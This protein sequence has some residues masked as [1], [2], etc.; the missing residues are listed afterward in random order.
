MPTEAVEIAR[1]ANIDRTQFQKQFAKP[2]VP[3]VIEGLSH[4]WPAYTKWTLDYFKSICGDKVVPLYDSSKADASK[5]VNQADHQMKFGDY[6]DL[7]ARE[8]TDL[9]IFTFNVIDEMPQIEADFRK[10][11]LCRLFVDRFPMMFF[12]GAGSKVFMHYDIDVPHIFLTQFHGSKRVLL[13]PPN[14]T[15]RLY[16]LPL[17][18]HAIEDIDWWNP[19]Y[20]KFPA[21]RGITGYTTILKHGET[22]YMPPGWW[23]YMEYLEGGFAIA[24]RAVASPWRAAEGAINVGLIR[25]IDN[26]LRKRAGTKW[27]E[28]KERKAYERSNAWARKH[29][30]TSLTPAG[31]LQ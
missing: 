19:D 21:L 18:W 8:P 13:F 10:P 5:K 27:W 11:D 26:F 16:K 12:G 22:L 9:R 7:I 28:Y 15:P 3:C 30:T 31:S 14:A 24:M 17:S 4:S 2:R 29:L 6:L 20:E 1:V 25:L 23:H